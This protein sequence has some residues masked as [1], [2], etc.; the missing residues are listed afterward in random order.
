MPLGKTLRLRRLNRRGRMVIVAV[1]HG[2]AAGIVPGL[3]NATETVAMC[4][5]AGADAVLITPGLLELCADHIGDL[6][7][8]LRIDGAVTTAGPGGPMRIYCDVEHAVALGVDAVVLN[9]TVGAPY[10]SV[11]LENIGR[12]SSEGRRWGMPV[13]AEVLSQRMLS[14]HMDFRGDGEAMLP[15]DI[16]SDVAMCCRLGAELGADAIKTRFCG[17]VEAFRRIVASAG[18][19][20]LVAGGP[21]RGGGLEA[22]LNLVNDVLEAGAAGVIFGRQIWQQPDPTA[23]LQAVCAMVHEDATVSEALDLTVA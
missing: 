22:T 20:I 2:N 10:E 9:A 21:N 4:D 12:T 14:N 17:D 16:A 19:P 6:G 15:E 18:R 11:E 5:A 3:E 23:A 1:D 13:L 8:I 7:V